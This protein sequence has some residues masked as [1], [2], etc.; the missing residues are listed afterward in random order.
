MDRHTLWINVDN[1]KR[2][3]FLKFEIKKNL[4]ISIKKSKKISYLNR[5]KSAFYLSSITR[6]SSLTQINNRC[7]FSGRNRSVLKKTAYSRF[8]FRNESY[9]GNIPGCRR[10][11][12]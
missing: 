8:Y 10:A 11:S 4:L 3:K 5:Y 12:W 2:K 9:E 7:S 6:S 1:Y